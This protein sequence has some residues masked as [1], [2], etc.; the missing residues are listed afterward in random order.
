MEFKEVSISK[1]IGMSVLTKILGLHY[2][3]KICLF[4]QIQIGEK[5]SLFIKKVTLGLNNLDKIT[6]RKITLGKTMLGKSILGKTT[7]GKMSWLNTQGKITLG[8]ITLG[9]IFLR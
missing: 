2:F 4:C 5:R 6:L 3:F 7:L 1:T 9:D 8:K